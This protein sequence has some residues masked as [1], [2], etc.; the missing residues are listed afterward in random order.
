MTFSEF[1]ER[2]TGGQVV[3]ITAEP[4]GDRQGQ[5]LTG[6]DT[7]SARADVRSVHSDQ[8]DERIFPR[9]FFKAVNPSRP[10]TPLNS[11]DL[12]S[13]H[14]KTFKSQVVGH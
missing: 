4:L 2:R 8:V 1:L 6:T 11:R 7:E 14:R 3:S 13:S 5:S 10:V 9:G 12:G